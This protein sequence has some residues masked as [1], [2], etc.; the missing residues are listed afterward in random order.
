MGSKIITSQSEVHTNLTKI[1][2]KHA[3]KNYRAPITSVQEEA[4][5]RC[6]EFLHQPIILDLGCGTG[7]STRHLSKIFKDDIIIGIDKSAHRLAKGDECENVKLIRADFHA[8]LYQA[9]QFGIKI[10]SCYLFYPNPWPKPGHLQRRLHGHPIFPYL[11]SLT[12]QIEVRSN[13]KIYCKE[14]LLATKQLVDADGTVDVY[15]DDNPV[16]LFERKYWQQGVAT[17]QIVTIIN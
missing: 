8:W 4:F 14:F 9:Y 6:R 7:M 16:S 11:L 10:K 5:N 3:E 17:Y 1:V 12:S 15:Q 13:W 2:Q